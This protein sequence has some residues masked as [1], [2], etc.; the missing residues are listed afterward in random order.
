MGK[1]K[2]L[3]ILF[4]TAILAACMGGC[5]SEQDD[6]PSASEAP[7]AASATSAPASSTATSAAE[8]ANNPSAISVAN[9]MIG[10]WTCSLLFYG[11]D[12]NGEDVTTGRYEG[13][14]VLTVSE[15]GYEFEFA[16]PDGQVAL[17]SH[18]T[19][20]TGV[21]ASYL[22]DTT[23]SDYPVAMLSGGAHDGEIKFLTEDHSEWVVASVFK[24]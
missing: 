15:H 11:H 6:T 2:L 13:D 21:Q 9:S 16:Y 7:S 8:S 4:A 3:A 18:G 23:L 17:S 22:G 1:T 19:F 20:T 12:E 5:S 10:E 24:S 14:G